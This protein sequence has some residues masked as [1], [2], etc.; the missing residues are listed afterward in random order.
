MKTTTPDTSISSTDTADLTPTTI[1]NLLA[2]DRRRYALHYLSQTVGAVSLGDLAEQI[3][4]W[5]DNPTYDH[6]E[7]VVTGL[8]HMHLP[9]L[10]DAGVVRYDVEQE[11]VELRE[12]A[13]ELT[14]YLKRVT[15]DDLQ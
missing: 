15:A 1:F 10:A 8:H 7:R 6:F 9:K 5:E 2:N 3:A 14:P 12:A 4:L 13:D 11:T